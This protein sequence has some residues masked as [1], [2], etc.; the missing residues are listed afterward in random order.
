MQIFNLHSTKLGPCSFNFSRKT[1]WGKNLPVQLLG[2]DRLEHLST[3]F[4]N[5]EGEFIFLRVLFCSCPLKYAAL[6]S[7]SFVLFLKLSWVY[8]WKAENVRTHKALVGAVR[9]IVF[10]GFGEDIKSEE[11]KDGQFKF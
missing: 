7:E 3:L 4:Y 10:D 5:T 6:F 2:N 8:V 11:R 9:I 1:H